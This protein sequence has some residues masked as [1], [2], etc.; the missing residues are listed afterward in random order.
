MNDMV[1]SPPHYLKAESDTTGELECI[2]AMVQV[3][4]KANVEMYSKINS[5][6]YIWRHRYKNDDESEDLKKAL[7]YLKFGTGTDPRT[8]YDK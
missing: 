6:K 3:F 7:W 1:N 4:G 5:F 2:D 8:E